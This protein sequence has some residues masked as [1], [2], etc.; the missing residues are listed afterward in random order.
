VVLDY[1]DQRALTAG[2]SRFVQELRRGVTHPVAR[3]VAYRLPDQR[4]TCAAAT[5]Y[6]TDIL[7]RPDARP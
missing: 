3:A 6:L 1:A 2:Y 7:L 4:A 5:R